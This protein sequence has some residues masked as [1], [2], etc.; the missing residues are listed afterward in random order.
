VRNAPRK[1]AQVLWDRA[2]DVMMDSYAGMVDAGVPVQDARGILPTN[3][4]T[5]IIAKFNLRT[6]HEMAKVRLCTR[7]AGEYQLVF[8]AMREEVLFVHPYFSEFI[9]VHCAATGT[10]AFPRYGR[11]QCRFYDPRMDTSKVAADT[12][13]KFWAA[14][15]LQVANPVAKGGK[16][17][18]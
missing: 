4:T 6:L 15:E 13:D 1:D 3:I 7:T 16:T 12:H 5:D 10:C 14:A 9:D 18:P 8:R 2:E 11:D 17:M